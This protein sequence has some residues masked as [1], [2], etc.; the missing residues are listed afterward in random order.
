MNDDFDENQFGDKFIREA[1]LTRE[2]EMK[3]NFIENELKKLKSASNVNGDENS[4]INNEQ[5]KIFEWIKMS[6][7]NKR[8]AIFDF[9]FSYLIDKRKLRRP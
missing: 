1:R 3:M 2:Q 9:L 5:V 6:I 8:K 4:D 7:I